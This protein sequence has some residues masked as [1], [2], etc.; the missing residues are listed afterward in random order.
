MFGSFQFGQP[1]FGQAGTFGVLAYGLVTGGDMSLVNVYGEDHETG[2]VRGGLAS[3]LASILG[4][5]RTLVDVDG[6]DRA[7]GSVTGSDRRIV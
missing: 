6:G 3:V 7:H 2:S 4:G 5:D 1:Q